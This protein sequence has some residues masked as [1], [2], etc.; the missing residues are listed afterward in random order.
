MDITSSVF[1][2]AIKYY[3]IQLNQFAETGV[4]KHGQVFS[5]PLL[6]TVVS[7]NF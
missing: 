5:S 3:N 1:Y 7:Y 2:T 6:K 4:V